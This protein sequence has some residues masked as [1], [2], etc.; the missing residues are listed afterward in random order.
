MSVIG[1]RSFMLRAGLGALAASLSLFL[2]QAPASAGPVGGISATAMLAGNKTLRTFTRPLVDWDSGWG[3]AEKKAGLPNPRGWYEAALG[4]R[5]KARILYLT[6]DDGPGEYTDRVL[7]LLKQYHAKATFF[8][9]GSRAAEHQSTLQRMVREGH[10]VAN[11]TWNHPQLTSLSKPA[12]ADQLARTTK[13]ASGTMGGCMRPPFGLINAQVA[14]VALGQG[15]QPILWNAHIEDW[16]SHPVSWHVS[17]LRAGTKPGN[18]ILMHDTTYA[19]YAATKAMLPE[20]QKQGWKL[21]VIPV[22]R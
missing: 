4:Q 3:P 14:K 8:V 7:A 22:C 20:W 16:N 21:Q 17:R 1:S 12:V 6:Y 2:G 9:M 5:T 11:H 10:A 19:A 15:L 18:I 13:A